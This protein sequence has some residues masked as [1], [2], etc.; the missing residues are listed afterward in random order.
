MVLFDFLIFRQRFSNLSNWFKHFLSI[1]GSY[2][3]I[4]S[5]IGRK[6]FVFKTVL[7]IRILRRSRF[8]N[9]FLIFFIL[10]LIY[11]LFLYFCLRFLDD[12]RLFRRRFDDTSFDSLLYLF[13]N[14]WIIFWD[15]L[16]RFDIGKTLPSKDI[17]LKLKIYLLPFLSD[18]LFFRY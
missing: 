11:F 9:Y 4:L 5:H 1:L 18:W 14:L 12:K 17:R 13:V 6:S 10:I 16:N 7:L 3:S 8:H 2:I 15:L